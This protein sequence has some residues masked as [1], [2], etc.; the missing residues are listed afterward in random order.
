MQV[1]V[2]KIDDK[3]RIV[4]SGTE[5]PVVNRNG[6]ALDG[7]GHDME[8]KAGRQAHYINEGLKKADES[9]REQARS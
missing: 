6:K 1:E 9:K 5:T 4:E 2:K 3:Y 8:D 7:G